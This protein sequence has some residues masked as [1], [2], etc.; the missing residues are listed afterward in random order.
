[1]LDLSYEQKI[2]S[3]GIDYIIGIDEVGRGPLAGPVVVGAVIFD[4]NYAEVSG[5]NDSKQIKKSKLPALAEHIKLG[6]RGWSLGVGSVNLINE[7]GIIFAL[8]HAISSV[9]S[10]IVEKSL[11]DTQTSNVALLIDGLAYKDSSQFTGI[12][13]QLHL[14]NKVIYQPKADSTIYSV[15]AASIIAKV[16]RDE[17][18]TELANKHLHYGWE[19]NA[20]YGTK[21]HREAILEYGVTEEHRALFCRKL[22]KLHL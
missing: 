11:I 18:M 21:K 12:C 19:Q 2:W 5:I 16:Y 4:K 6:S 17:L 14:D 13:S 7:H 3:E 8:Q 20:G 22:L 15:A 1:M 10:T 9:I